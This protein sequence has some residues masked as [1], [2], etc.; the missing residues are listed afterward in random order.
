MNLLK[1]IFY[2]RSFNTFKSKPVNVEYNVTNLH[3]SYYDQHK[4]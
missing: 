4:Q 3:N 2:F 1:Y